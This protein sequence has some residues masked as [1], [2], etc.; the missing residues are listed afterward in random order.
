MSSSIPKVVLSDR[1]VELLDSVKLSPVVHNTQIGSLNAK[2]LLE[3]M[4][5]CV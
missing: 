4:F 5:F 1:N 2:K 3:A